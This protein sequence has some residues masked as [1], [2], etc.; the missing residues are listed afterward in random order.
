MNRDLTPFDVI[1]KLHSTEKTTRQKDLMISDKT[2][3][4]KEDKPPL[5]RITFKVD[6]RAN[7]L[8]IRDAVE[9][10]FPVKVKSVNTMNVHG[11][12]R[13]QQT[14]TPGFTPNWKKAIVTLKEGTIEELG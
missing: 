11:K 5:P 8:Q 4:M 13:R 6:R 3:G 10:L 1:K 12:P 2:E 9:R 14:R 7:K